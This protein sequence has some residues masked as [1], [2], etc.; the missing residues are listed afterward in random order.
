MFESRS[1]YQWNLY[2]TCQLQCQ[3][4]MFFFEPKIIHVE[5]PMGACQTPIVII[6]FGFKCSAKSKDFV[7]FIFNLRITYIFLME[8]T[9]LF[10][11]V[12]V[13]QSWIDQQIKG[14][15]IW[16]NPCSS[17]QSKWLMKSK[18][19]ISCSFNILEQWLFNIVSG[20]G[21]VA[22]FLL[23]TSHRHPVRFEHPKS[24]FKEC[25]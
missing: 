4:Y 24:L 9:V 2:A 19:S 1:S 21:S 16:L 14:S 13:R 15:A 8:Q 7:A 3:K 10:L 22:D 11:D 25:F 23:R 17:N 6:T 20:K 12:I 5:D 18:Y